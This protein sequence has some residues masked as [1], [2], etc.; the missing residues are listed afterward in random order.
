[1]SKDYTKLLEERFGAE[2]G[3]EGEA[4]LHRDV[5]DN[6][7]GSY[8]GDAPSG[9]PGVL[10]AGPSGPC[11]TCG[12]M[13]AEMDGSCG[14]ESEEV[15]VCSKCG[16]MP[17]DMSSGQCGCGAVHME[18]VKT[19]CEMCGGDVEEG[20]CECG[21]T[22]MAEAKRRKKKGGLTPTG[23]RKWLKG[24]HGSKKAAAKKAEKM[25]AWSP[26]GFAQYAKQRSKQ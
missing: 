25:G 14:C 6:K 20:I 23:A 15:D 24:T 22:S 11:S 13:P 26:Y 16:M 1:M 21:Y 18:A 12:M 9:A 2:L 7:I 3:A 5:F 8:A 19:T 4:E 17:T 10:L